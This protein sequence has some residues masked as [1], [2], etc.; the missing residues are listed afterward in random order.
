MELI[1][2]ASV[3]F[4]S[5]RSTPCS[6]V[7]NSSRDSLWNSRSSSESSA[8]F[9][10]IAGSSASGCGAG[11]LD[12]AP[13]KFATGAVTAL[14]VDWFHVVGSRGHFP[15]PLP[16]REDGTH[17]RMPIIQKPDGFAGEFPRPVQDLVQQRSDC[18][19]TRCKD[20]RC[21]FAG[22]FLEVHDQAVDRQETGV[23]TRLDES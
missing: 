6:I 22:E 14:P 7:C 19:Q 3:G 16:R 13:P 17:P 10:R 2:P 20:C 23:L 18:S 1:V 12:G 5:S 15:A 4:S 9:K 8:R 21:A 11:D